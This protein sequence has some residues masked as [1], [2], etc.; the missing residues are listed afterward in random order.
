MT[1]SN[2]LKTLRA[3]DVLVCRD[4]TRRTFAEYDEERRVIWASENDDPMRW[5]MAS[6]KCIDYTAP[7]NEWDIVCVIPKRAEKK[8][9]DADVA[10]LLKYAADHPSSYTK[11]RLRRI[12]KRLEE[13]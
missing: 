11:D 1:L 9:G 12:A 2:D 13:A 6:G 10:W 7:G 8:R 5:D 3:G 4:G